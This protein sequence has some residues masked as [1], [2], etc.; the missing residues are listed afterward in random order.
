MAGRV[1]RVFDRY[2]ARHLTLSQPGPMIPDA[3]GNPI[4][5]ITRI[6]LQQGRLCVEGESAA[7]NPAQNM[8][9]NPVQN[10]VLELAGRR[11]LW[12]EADTPRFRLELPFSSDQASLSYTWQDQALRLALPGFSPRR[13]QAARLALWP[14]F[15]AASLWALPSAWRWLRHHDLAAR[16][17]IKQLLG[18]GAM[19]EDRPLEAAV[20]PAQAP[21]RTVPA[22]GAT[23][24]LPVYQG[25]DLLAEVLDRVQ[26]HTDL[27]WHLLVI[28][29][30]SPDP[31]V[32]TFLRQWVACE[33]RATLL[34]NPENLGF[35]GT[36]NRAF[37]H[38]SA[39]G[40]FGPGPVILLNADAFVPQAWASR[41]VAPLLADPSVASVTPMSND[42]ELMTAPVICA[43]LGLARG[44]VD[45][46]DA[47]AQLLLPDLPQAPTGVG[48]CMAISPRY[49]A[50]VP[51]FDTAFG[52]GYGEEVDW[53]QRVRALGGRH[54]CLSNLFV[55]HRGGTSFGS[56]AKQQLIRQNG[57][58]ITQRYPRFD[59]EVQQFIADDPL[60]TPRLALGLAWAGTL[61]AGAPTPLYIGHAM[62]GG[63]EHYL[64]ARISA[65]LKRLGAAVVLRLGGEYRWQIEVHSTAGITRGCSNDRA[66][67]LRLL[68]LIPQ[69]HVIYS[70]GVSDPDPV[71]LPALLLDLAEGQRLEI[72]VHDYLMISPAF[73]LLDSHDAFHGVPD[74]GGP[75]GRSHRLQRPDGS[76]VDLAAWRK[77]WGAA[78]A[79]AHQV[80]VFSQD[81]QALMHAAYPD[82]GARLVLRPHQLAQT[83]PRLSPARGTPPVIGVLGNIG[84]HKGAG[85]LVA[86]S[87][88][89]ARKGARAEAG[90]VL[91]G[92]LDPA[93]N[94]RRP[95][96]VHGSY[97]VEDIPDLVA[98]YDIT[99]WLI[100]SIWPETFSFT[101]HEALATGL[102]VICFD[103]GAQAEAV[104]RAMA[105]G[106]AG[107][108][109]SLRNGRADPAALVAEAT[110]LSARAP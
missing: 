107:A 71:A 2:A 63:A 57:A 6:S 51:Q 100:P 25:F 9:Q 3:Q 46:I 11:R 74:P 21:L 16:A 106:G 35:I 44:A 1:Q 64:Q 80:T 79:A 22:C 33:P 97:A 94:L 75:S 99:C 39:A 60:L 90:L 87:Q 18:L 54:L 109:V 59:I 48:F 36:M 26:R 95:A 53:C 12:T 73:T 49:L 61:G 58:L 98:R 45:Q 86:L 27:P 66:L 62:G 101:T 20:F 76:W 56:Q 102:P 34:E 32:A 14:R 31:R 8:G 38:L 15:A 47:V 83:P 41:L 29:D 40:G 105:E 19:V 10:L 23:I 104:R 37:A 52:R 77:A 30:A 88:H 69:R 4:G 67:M 68:R 82:L 43:P 7:Q 5:Q 13:L 50:Q 70:C 85:V 17:R 78:L 89:L 81:S 72:L 96:R 108:V 55:E 84:G 24:V 91:L 103:L 93:Y 28:D 110:R 65:D 42:A 92:N